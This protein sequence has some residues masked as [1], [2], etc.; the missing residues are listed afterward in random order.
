MKKLAILSIGIPGSGKTTALSM[1]SRKYHMRRISRDDI[2]Q[3]WFGNPHV[4][5]RK[6]AVRREAEKRMIDAL[7]KNEPVLLDSTFIDSL[8]RQRN[9]Q[10]VRA[11]GAERVIGV[12]FT[13][14]L[15]KAK[16]R[17]RQR[18]HAVP[19]NVIEKMHQKLALHP[20]TKAEGFDALYTNDQL[21]QLEARELKGRA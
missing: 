8:D 1:L 12:V 21:G 19:E 6:D 17:N 15:S 16:M 7:E 4:Q 14:S 9:I 3:E 5:E 11:A 18:V 2:R 20:P 10:K 13:T